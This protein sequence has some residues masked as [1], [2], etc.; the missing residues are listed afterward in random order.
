LHSFKN[1]TKAGGGRGPHDHSQQISQAER[2]QHLDRF[3]RQQAHRDRRGG[4][5]PI[6]H[7]IEATGIAAMP[8]PEVH[9]RLILHRPS[10]FP[11]TPGQHPFD[12][13]VGGGS[14]EV[15]AEPDDIDV[16]Q[17]RRRD[18]AAAQVPDGIA[19]RSGGNPAI[20]QVQR[21]H[22][23]QRR[24]QPTRTKSHADEFNGMRIEPFGHA[25]T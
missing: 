11:Q 1:D 4:F 16:V 6:I 13:P 14:I 8:M 20:G 25:P 10:N 7:G 2:R 21:R 12:T 9:P 23:A 17:G 22:G 18:E 24:D 3:V 5:G 19:H 15:L